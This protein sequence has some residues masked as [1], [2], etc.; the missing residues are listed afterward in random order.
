MPDQKDQQQA[1]PPP[2]QQGEA[3]PAPPKEDHHHLKNAGKNVGKAAEFGFGATLGS[4]AAKNL[5]GQL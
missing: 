1:P 3:P 2:P 4:D 5:V